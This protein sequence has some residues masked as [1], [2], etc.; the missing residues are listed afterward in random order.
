MSTRCRLL[1]VIQAVGLAGMTLALAAPA[2]AQSLPPPLG[3]RIED[4]D[5]LAV[6]Y[7]GNWSTYLSTSY[8]GATA[9]LSSNPGSTV[10]VAF[11]GTGL[12]WIGDR[13]EWS[14]IA[15]VYLDGDFLA[16]VDGYASPV[17]YQ[18]TLFSVEGLPAASHRLTIQVLGTHSG[19]SGG[20]GVWADAF[21][22]VNEGSP[23]APDD[24]WPSST[25]FEQDDAA[26]AYT[27]TWYPNASDAHSGGSAVQSEELD[28]RAT[29]SFSGT[30]VRWIGV[31]DEWSGIARVYLDGSLV[32]IID[33]YG[34]PTQTQAVIFQTGALASGPHSL[35]VEATHSHGQSAQQKWVWVDAFDVV[36]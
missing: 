27:G 14:G 25:R 4:N 29:F 24:P 30:R 31:R 19:A 33:T 5:Y 15:A 2:G 17:E 10:T 36:P 13:D 12:R 18:A 22:V 21:D 9:A 8:S 6:S 23:P 20:I 11:D 3:T 35:A 28:A 1:P 7:S 26:V 34:S 16:T 32:G